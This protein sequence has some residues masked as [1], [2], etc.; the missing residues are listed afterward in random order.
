MNEIEQ[1]GDLLFNES[2]SAYN[3]W[4][5]GGKAKQ[6]FKPKNVEGLQAFL[7]HLPTDEPI[8]WLGLGSNSLISDQGFNG[9]VIL[10]QGCLKNISLLDANQIRAEAGVSC[11]QLA[12]FCA[13]NNLA[14]AEFLAGIPGTFGGALRMNAGCY[15]AETWDIVAEVE[16]ID[17]DGQIRSCRPEDFIINYRQVIGLKEQEWFLAGTIKLPAGS[18]TESMQKIKDLLARRAAT[19]PTGQY[20]CGSVF[21]NPPGDYAARLIEAC[22]LKGYKLGGAQVSEKHANFIIN[23]QA[24]ASAEDISNLINFV[25]NAVKEK[26]GIELQQEVH[27]IGS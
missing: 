26:Y 19:Q 3:T 15:Q 21:R 5:V 8:L 10:T 9:T 27:F 25:R 12:R 24:N 2:L 16:T 23:S 17:R 18:S 20:N 1:H 14:A 11:A 22:G 7:Q 13:R 6:L 4:R